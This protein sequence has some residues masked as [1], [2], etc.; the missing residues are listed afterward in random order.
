MKQQFIVI[1]D[2]DQG[3]SCPMGWDKDCEGAI[4]AYT[5]GEG[6]AVFGNKRDARK[7][8]TISRR[9]ALLCESQGKPVNTDFTEGLKN[10]RIEPLLP[11]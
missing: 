5:Y 9:S 2:D 6:I 7:A 3:L 11:R 4:V 8:I 1:F 10:I